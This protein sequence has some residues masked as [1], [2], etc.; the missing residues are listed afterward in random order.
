[1][2][3]EMYRRGYS[4]VNPQTPKRKT[5]KLWHGFVLLQTTIVWRRSFREYFLEQKRSIVFDSGV[6]IWSKSQKRFATSIRPCEEK[7]KRWNK[8]K[9]KITATQE[10]FQRE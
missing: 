2:P 9:A 3:L 1:M 5:V 7:L 4:R 10:S 6:Y 8:L